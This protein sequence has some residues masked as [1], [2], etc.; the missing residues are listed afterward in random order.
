MGSAATV[1]LCHKLTAVPHAS[2]ERCGSEEA[3]GAGHGHDTVG[4]D[5]I[6]SQPAL[7]FT[8]D[9]ADGMRREIVAEPIIEVPHPIAYLPTRSPPAA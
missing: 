2:Q 1:L 6:V 3:A 9:V 5:Q 8:T 4:A 7:A